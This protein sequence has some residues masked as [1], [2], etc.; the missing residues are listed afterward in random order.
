MRTTTTTYE[1]KSSVALVY[2]SASQWSSILTKLSKGT[3]VEVIS[4]S[5]NWAYFIY[6]G[7]DAYIKC[8]SIKKIIASILGTITI[9]YINLDTEEEISESAIY[10]NL[11]LKSYTY[12]AK[13][14]AG[15][16]LSDESTKTITLAQDNPNQTIAFYYKQIWGEITVKYID[17]D[18]NSEISTTDIYSDLPLG[19]YSYSAKTIEHYTANSTTTQSVTL[20]ETN[21]NQTLIFEYKLSDNN[22]EYIVDL[23]MF[24]IKK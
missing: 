14:I 8:N 20:T 1:V 23:S 6:N 17:I 13:S 2:S 24:N 16:T 15:Y 18:T 11:E 5:K 19:T 10:S 7:K 12:E 9:K 3:Q 22:N 4:I 21:T